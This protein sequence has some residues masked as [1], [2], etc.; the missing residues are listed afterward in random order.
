M[1]RNLPEC[2]PLT[3]NSQDKLHQEEFKLWKG[4][5]S[6]ASIRRKLECE[7]CLKTFSKI[8]ARHNMQNQTN[9]KHFSNSEYILK[10]TKNVL[11]GLNTKE[12]SS[13]TTTS[14][15]L[16]KIRQNLQG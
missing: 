9:A 11:E 12:D 6:C 8:F 7:K 2:K 5:K 16:S 15:V 1:L 13:N 14:I 10:S 4:A 3:E